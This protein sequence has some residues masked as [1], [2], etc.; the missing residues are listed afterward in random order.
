LYVAGASTSLGGSGVVNGTGSATNFSYYGLPSNTSVSFSGN[1]AFVGTIYAP[2]AA[3]Q[4][5]GGGSN[6]FDFVGASVSNTVQMNGHFNFH[7]DELLGR[8][9]NGASYYITSWNEI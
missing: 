5:G 7:Y 1:A 2:N 6:T 3:L 4:L 8:Q 9:N